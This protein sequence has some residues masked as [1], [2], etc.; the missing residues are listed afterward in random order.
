MRLEFIIRLFLI[1]LMR[2][3]IKKD[4]SDNGEGLLNGKRVLGSS[5]VLKISKKTYR[6]YYSEIFSGGGY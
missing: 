1:V 2:C 4:C 6:I 5:I 3:L